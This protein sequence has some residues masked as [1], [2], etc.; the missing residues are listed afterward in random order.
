MP[1][2][3]GTDFHDSGRKTDFSEH[4]WRFDDPLCD[5]FQEI[6]ERKSDISAFPFL[7]SGREP[8]VGAYVSPVPAIIDVISVTRV[9]FAEN[10]AI[11]TPTRD[12]R[13]EFE[14]E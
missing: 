4:F 3:A 11:I 10:P 9:Q 14:Q 5:V 12:T 1:S 8:A 2:R 6:T 7:N 13:V